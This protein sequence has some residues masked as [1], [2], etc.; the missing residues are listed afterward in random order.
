MISLTLICHVTTLNLFL[1]W[2]L[3]L[4]LHVSVVSAANEADVAQLQSLPQPQGRASHHWT[5]GS[6]SGDGHGNS[7]YEWIW[8]NGPN[9][10]DQHSQLSSLDTP[11]Y[12]G[13][14]SGTASW[15]DTGGN[16]WMFGGF[17]LASKTTRIAHV[18]NDLWLWNATIGLW[19]LVKQKHG[20]EKVRV[21]PQARHQAAACGV[22]GIMFILFGGM[23]PQGEPL[24]DTW[25]FD[26]KLSMWLPLY[27]HTSTERVKMI[28]PPARSHAAAWC[29]RDSLVVFSGQG[30]TGG[31]LLTDMWML[32]LRNLTWVQLVDRPGIGSA[33]GDDRVPLPRA[34]ATTW[35]RSGGSLYLFGG[36]KNPRQTQDHLLHEAAHLTDTT[37]LLA[38]LWLFSIH[39]FTWTSLHSGSPSEP[40][41]QNDVGARECPGHRHL[42]MSWG[43]SDSHLWLFGGNGLKDIFADKTRSDMLSDVWTY[44][45]TL[46]QWL[47]RTRGA[48]P[49]DAVYNQRGQRQPV[50]P[51]GRRGATVW[52][53][54]DIVYIT[55]GFGY[56]G[57]RKIA[58]LNDMWLY[59]PANASIPLYVS[60][61]VERRKHS[62][63]SGGA[64]FA[65]SLSTF[66]GAV[67]IMGLYCFVKNFGNLP[68]FHRSSG[69]NV[70]YSPL[71]DE[72]HVG[73]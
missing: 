53:Y 26:I 35:T 45:L 16:V 72:A 7:V 31:F 57:R 25:I 34:G 38:D 21:V 52:Q 68:N 4:Q 11:Q 73:T 23:G 14:R 29:T 62:G 49:G 66:G 13:S 50:S 32:S 10:G 18:L 64:V 69:Y 3:R 43:D 27:V 19:T 33:S 6:A 22:A 24:Y 2:I 63:L 37:V 5:S 41:G 8:M 12:P 9:L 61:E 58:Y 48:S 20:D 42:S 60:K 28:H 40:P 15:R 44:H 54:N 65:I 46:K 70:R 17:G 39:D 56:D 1:T 30:G 47:C 55:G 67:L 71:F 36:N 51:T 59:L